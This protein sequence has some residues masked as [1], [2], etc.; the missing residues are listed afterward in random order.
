MAP[1][2][3]CRVTL[4]FTIGGERDER[5]PA[6]WQKARCELLGDKW[7]SRARGGHV[8]PVP[9]MQAQLQFAANL[10]LPTLSRSWLAR[11]QRS[12]GVGALPLPTNPALCLSCSTQQ[13]RSHPS[14]GILPQ[15][16]RTQLDA[17]PLRKGVR[18][19]STELTRWRTLLSSAVSHDR[20]GIDFV[21]MR[22]SLVQRL[23]VSP[24]VPSM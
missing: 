4:T 1:L 16:N 9:N 2:M 15:I 20:N 17:V 24:G 14:C 10:T 23:D 22:T 19:S 21:A 6:C 3:L 18:V 13:W 7:P 11:L 12:V 8:Y 5:I